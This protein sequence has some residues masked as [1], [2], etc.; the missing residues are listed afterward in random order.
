LSQSLQQSQRVKVGTEVRV[1]PRVI[2]S[3]HMLQLSRQELDEAIELELNDNPALERLEEEA[4]PI[5]DELVLRTVAPVELKPSSE[6][7][8]FRRCLPPDD[9]GHADWTELVASGNSL[10]DHLRAQLLPSLPSRLAAL[11]DYVISSVNERGYLDSPIE[12]IALESDSPLEDVELVVAALKNCEPA[13]VGAFDIQECLLL[14]LRREDTLEAKLAR[15]IVKHHMDDLVAR[16]TSRIMRRYRVLPEVVEAAFEEILALTPYPGEGFSA[17]PTGT[18]TTARA[19]ITPDLAI[20]IRDGRWEIDV[21]GADPQALAV[22][23]SYLRR[24]RQLSEMSRPPKDEKAHIA[25]YVERASNFIHSIAQRRQTLRR[26]GEYLIENQAGFVSTGRYQFLKPLT[27]SRLARD[28]GMHESTVSRATMR[29]YVQ[30]VTGEVVPFDVF[31]KPALR[32]Q[33]MIEEIMTT[34]NPKD[35]LSDEQIAAL[36]AKRGV[37]VARR[38]VNKYRDR[39]KL[40]SSH[41]RRTA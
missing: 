16:R 35:P 27:R 40:P 30:I 12:E 20:S 1:D 38:T 21:R 34:E 8:E 26:I 2:L 7:I 31:F 3:S 41:R 9:S 36:L 14:Q 15:A 19:G 33:K 28:I 18:F 4:E 17:G 13:G 23:R 10:W 6:D 25:E 32:V 24:Q 29:K 22:S 39:T 37:I 5:T 11:A